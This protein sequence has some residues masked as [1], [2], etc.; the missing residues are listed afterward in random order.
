[1]QG[2]ERQRKR[3]LFQCHHRGVRELDLV[4]GAFAD[5]HLAQL[6][7][8]DLGNLDTFLDEP[9]PDIFDWLVGQVPL[10][11]RLDNAVTRRL[12]AFGRE[13]LMGASSAKP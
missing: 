8:T 4:L 10:P 5:R 12:V 2:T 9:D 6:D 7:A 13:R 1:M 11:P 3:L